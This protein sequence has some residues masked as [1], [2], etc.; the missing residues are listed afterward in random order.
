MHHV[1]CKPRRRKRKDPT[2]ARVK[3]LGGDGRVQIGANQILG[4]YYYKNVGTVMHT[5]ERLG[6][7]GWEGG[8]GN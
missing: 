8:W 2:F 3:A 4:G 1:L 6:S 7:D 5:E